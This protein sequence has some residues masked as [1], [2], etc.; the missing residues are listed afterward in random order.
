MLITFSDRFV[1]LFIILIFQFFILVNMIFAQK[2][3]NAPKEFITIQKGQFFKN[4]KP[5][6]FLGTN[7]WAAMNLGIAGNEAYRARLIRELDHLQKLG[8]NNL[9]IMAASE[10]PDTEP[11]RMVP[12]LQPALGEYNENLLLG[13]DFLLA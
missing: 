8:V 5:Y 4:D 3:V 1:R 11:W 9:R 10:G 2:K 7:F 13:L 6:Y 12:A